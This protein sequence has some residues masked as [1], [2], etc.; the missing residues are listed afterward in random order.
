MK[1]IYNDRIKKLRE[2]LKDNDLDA[3]IIFSAENRYYLSG[4]NAED[5]QINESSGVLIISIDNLIIST[6]ARFETQA[7][8]EAPDF[9][10]VI[11]KKGLSSEIK[12]IFKKFQAKKIGFESE[13]VS[14]STYNTLLKEIDSDIELVPSDDL[15]A[16]IRIIKTED[17]IDVIRKAIGIAEVAFKDTVG[18]LK[19]GM[20]EKEIAWILEQNIKNRGGDGLS[21]TSII[22]YGKNSALPHAIP[23]N[24]KIKKGGPLL[25]DWGVK[26]EGYCS[27]T[28]R[29]LS[30]GEPDS[31]FLKVYNTV[32]KAQSLAMD[33][34]KDGESSV[35]VDKAARDYINESGF[36]GK[37]G[38]GLGHG[39]GLEVHEPPR[40]S[41]IKKTIIKE[42]MIVTV[43]PGIYL[44]EWGGVRLENMAV[45]RKECA[46]V[47]NTLSYDDYIVEI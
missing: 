36:E 6:D 10:P 15:I 43:E 28:S 7:A 12:S 40:L 16:E 21:F 20:T 37:F 4:F 25:F 2:K 26:Y 29:T 3:M 18:A 42:G 27:D 8:I 45:V 1:E 46:E 35:E 17:E 9:E 30:I 24:N 11:Y 14:F 22:A 33:K 5:S 19:E 32:F 23:G 13:R 39:V 31:H 38:H 34:I 41:P 44:P 47:L